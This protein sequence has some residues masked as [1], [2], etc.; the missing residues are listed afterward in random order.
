MEDQHLVLTQGSWFLG[1]EYLTVH[2]QVRNFIMR[3]RSRNSKA[4]VSIANISL[5]YFDQEFLEIIG[6]KTRRIIGINQATENV[7]CDRLT[8]LSI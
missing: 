3:S 7:E 5:E 4:L 8:W 6:M 1:H 2:K